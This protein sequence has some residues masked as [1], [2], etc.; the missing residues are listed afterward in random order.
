M[1]K[2][3][4]I[5]VI[6]ILSLFFLFLTYTYKLAPELSQKNGGEFAQECNNLNGKA[7]LFENISKVNGFIDLNGHEKLTKEQFETSKNDEIVRI[8]KNSWFK[9][10]SIKYS[11]I[12]EIRQVKN[13]N[14]IISS[15]KFYWTD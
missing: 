14:N 3:L 10:P 9:G 5:V 4:L 15:A 2:R 13:S 11:W 1:N 6:V 12:C 8:Y 7:Y